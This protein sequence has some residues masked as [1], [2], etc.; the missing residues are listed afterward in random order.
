MAQINIAGLSAQIDTTFSV[1]DNTFARTKQPNTARTIE[2]EVGDKK[3]PALTY[4]QF[5]TK[6]WDNECN[7]SIR[8]VDDDY[9]GATIQTVGDAIEWERA[10]RKARFYEKD[11]GDEDGGFEF[12]VEY[13]SKPPTNIIEFSIQ[14][15]GL[16]F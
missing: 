12:E 5:K 7:L 3:Q 1:A 4:P 11:T 16:I 14:K 15:K 8:L 2:I 6:H 10:G 9:A 13:A